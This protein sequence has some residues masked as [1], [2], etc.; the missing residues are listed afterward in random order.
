MIERRIKKIDLIW[1][2]HEEGWWEFIKS[3]ELKLKNLK[4]EK[5]NKS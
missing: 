4:I 5:T 2:K 3:V 1:I